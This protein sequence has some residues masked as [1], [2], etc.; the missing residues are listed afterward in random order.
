MEA[1]DMK[2]SHKKMT[3]IADKKHYIRQT[4]DF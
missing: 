3:D 1:N 2:I 4:I